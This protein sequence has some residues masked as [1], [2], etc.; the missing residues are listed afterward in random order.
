MKPGFYRMR[1]KVGLLCVVSYKESILSYNLIANRQRQQRWFT[2]HREAKNLLTKKKYWSLRV[3]GLCPSCGGE[4]DRE[5]LVLCKTC[6]GVRNQK[7][8]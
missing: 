1:S 5:G 7:K 4:R 6:A 3:A 8:S 2:A